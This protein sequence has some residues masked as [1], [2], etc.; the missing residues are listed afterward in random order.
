MYRHTLAT[1]V[2]RAEYPAALLSSSTTG[3]ISGVLFVHSMLYMLAGDPSDLVLCQNS[4]P[5][6]Q[7]PT[8]A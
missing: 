6:Q 4:G 1:P 3:L 2:C 5:G 8:Q 7:W